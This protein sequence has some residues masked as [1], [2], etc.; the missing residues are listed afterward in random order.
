MT[1]TFQNVMGLVGQTLRDPREGASTLLNYA[2]VRAVIWQML[3][4]VIVVSVLLAHA[5]E[6]LFSSATA[7]FVSGPFALSP[8]AAVAVQGGLLVLTVYAAYW[9]G[10]A[11]GGTGSFEEAL[12]LITWMQ[13]IFV[14]LQ[15]VQSLAFIFF[16]VVAGLIGIVALGLFFWLLTNFIAVLHGFSSL[17]LVLV[18]IIGSAIGIVMG[19]S[20]VLAILGVTVPGI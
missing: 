19:L 6:A 10:K 4:F 14:V 5:T 9:I 7:E 13:F 11:F 20:L 2:P 15:V 17:G 16:P 18:G 3:L 8:F 1:W 12:L